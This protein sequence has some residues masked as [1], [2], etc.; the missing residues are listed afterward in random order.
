MYQLAPW[1]KQVIEY[2]PPHGYSLNK[3]IRAMFRGS[4]GH[5]LSIPMPKSGMSVASRNEG[6]TAAKRVDPI[7][8]AETCILCLR[9]KLLRIVQSPPTEEPGRNTPPR[10]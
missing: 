3:A 2:L 6:Q 9:S 7:L 1:Q 5:L 8:P 4:E 10:Q